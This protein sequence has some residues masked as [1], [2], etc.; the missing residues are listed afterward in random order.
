VSNG[1]GIVSNGNGIDPLEERPQEPVVIV[2][3]DGHLV[4]VGGATVREQ[5][6]HVTR[7][8]SEWAQRQGLAAFMDNF[9]TL[10]DSLLANHWAFLDA[11]SDKKWPGQDTQPVGWPAPPNDPDPT[12]LAQAITWVKRQ[13]VVV[14]QRQ[15]LLRSQMSFVTYAQ[16]REAQLIRLL[17]KVC[18]EQIERDPTLVPPGL[19]GAM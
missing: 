10:I 7:L 4:S 8:Q 12:T 16:T 18:G 6:E 3:P 17:L 11:Y 15:E 5:T 14:N 2:D 9:N 1:H 13:M 19:R